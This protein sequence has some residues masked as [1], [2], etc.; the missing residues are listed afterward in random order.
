MFSVKS[1]PARQERDRLNVERQ[2]QRSQFVLPVQ[3]L[4]RVGD[5]LSAHP[6]LRI[7]ISTM[8]PNEDTQ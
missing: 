1:L 6:R 7:V 4:G 3:A 2:W 5:P 8:I